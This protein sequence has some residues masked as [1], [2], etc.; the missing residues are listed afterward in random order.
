MQNNS[1]EHL[2]NTGQTHSSQKKPSDLT[3][4][5]ENVK[6]GS[7]NKN[8]DNCPELVMVRYMPK[9]CS[10]N[11]HCGGKGAMHTFDI[12]FKFLLEYAEDYVLKFGL[13]SARLALNLKPLSAKKIFPQRSIPHTI[14]QKHKR[15]SSYGAELAPQTPS[16]SGRQDNSI[17]TTQILDQVVWI[18]TTKNPVCFIKTKD[19]QILVGIIENL[20]C[21]L[22]PDKNSNCR[23]GYILSVE[24]GDWGYEMECDLNISIIKEAWSKIYIRSY[25]NDK[26]EVFRQNAKIKLNNVLSEGCWKCSAKK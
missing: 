21:E 25:A 6:E 20:R 24:S 10:S 13:K 14:T 1:D 19:S 9:A 4:F 11:G 3:P 22:V 18:G 16:I 8:P 2:V 17:S 7:K 12:S 5:R 26:V 23:C 15:Q